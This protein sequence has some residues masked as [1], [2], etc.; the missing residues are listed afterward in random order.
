MEKMITVKWIRS[1]IGRT[2]DQ[3]ETIRG[4]GFKRLHETLTLPDR[5]EIR[6]M[7]DHVAHLLEVKEQ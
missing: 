7:V 2:R 6:G 1:V 4:L 5:P 3:R